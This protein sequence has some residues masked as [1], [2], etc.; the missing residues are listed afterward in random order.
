MTQRD[1]WFEDLADHLG[2]AYDRYAHTK[3]TAQEIDHLV[4]VLELVP[5][6]RVLDVGCGTGRHAH[7]LARRGVAVHGVDISAR[8]VEIAQA[9]APTGRRSSGSTPAR[10]RSPASSMPWSASAKEVSA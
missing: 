9:R 5:G 3:G 10:C 1:H 6:A 7:E 8:F 4:D 2:E